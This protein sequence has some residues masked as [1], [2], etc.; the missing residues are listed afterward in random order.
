M[1]IAIPVD[2]NNPK[3]NVCVSFG[4]AP[5]FMIYNTEDKKMD[6]VFNKAA[7]AEGGAG[8]KAAQQIVDNEANVVLTIRCGQNA[9]EVLQAAEIK[10]YKTLNGNAAENIADYKEGKL[11]VL[12][13]FHAGFHGRR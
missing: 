11:D 10:I 9:A 3:T 4:R 6:F 7:N 5:Y 12:T 2:E 13:Q 8:I 1:K